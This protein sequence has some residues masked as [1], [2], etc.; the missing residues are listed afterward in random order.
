MLFLDELSDAAAGWL[1]G[2]AWPGNYR[3]LERLLADATQVAY[4]R[5]G[6]ETRAAQVD[7]DCLEQA[8]EG[9]AVEP[10]AASNGE[11][12][13]I[14]CL[15]ARGMVAALRRHE[16]RIG[17]AAEACAVLGMKSQPRFIAMLRALQEYLPDDVRSHP[18]IAPRLKV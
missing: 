12:V 5:W 1:A 18:K 6:G 13:D 2:R 4:L 16:F 11:D 17:L 15:A 10:A 7:T 9:H 8:L 14:A 3:E